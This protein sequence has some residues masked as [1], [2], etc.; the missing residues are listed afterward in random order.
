M[1]W[2]KQYLFERLKWNK[3]GRPRITKKRRRPHL[4]HKILI[5]WDISDTF[6]KNILLYCYLSILLIKSCLFSFCLTTW[7]SHLNFGW[8]RQA[9]WTVPWL[10]S[11]IKIILLRALFIRIKYYIQLKL[12]ISWNEHT[13]KHRYILR[14]NFLLYISI[15]LIKAKKTNTGWISNIAFHCMC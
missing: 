15:G 12:G 9:S 5:I 3:L 4:P 14:N 10:F 11:N 8:Y 2:C 7:R 1:P 6:F 13:Y